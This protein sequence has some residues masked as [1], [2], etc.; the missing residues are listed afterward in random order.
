[1][2]LDTNALSEFLKG[3]PIVVNLA[4]NADVVYLP[5]I[6]L[7]EYRYGLIYSQLR[8]VLTAQLDDYEREFPILR[9]DEFTARYYAT[10]RSNLRAKGRP[11]P[12]NDIW[13]A[14][15]ALQH[16]LPVL[17]RDSHFDEVAG[18]QRVTW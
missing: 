8:T 15:L 1:M 9:I 6:I 5:V 16:N 13:I 11:I 12:V 3:Q 2:I 10:V 7:G 14:A 4:A 18:L 17:S